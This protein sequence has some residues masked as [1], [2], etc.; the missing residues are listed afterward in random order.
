MTNRQCR[1]YWQL[2]Q[3]TGEASEAKLRACQA[4]CEATNRSRCDCWLREKIGN[5]GSAPSY[6][7]EQQSKQSQT[8]L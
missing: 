2:F 3:L 4:I 1:L 8:L 7:F 5:I 6:C